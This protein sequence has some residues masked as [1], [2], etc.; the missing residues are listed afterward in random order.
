MD[1][2]T[3]ALVARALA[4]PSRVRILRLIAEQPECRGAEIFSEL[5]LAQST[6]SEHLRMLKEAGLVAAHPTGTSMLYCLVPDVLREFQ[7]AVGEL[8]S[9]AGCVLAE[10]KC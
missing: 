7:D 2:E 1:D 8:A 3:L 4:H 9:T 6:I 5:P 10:E